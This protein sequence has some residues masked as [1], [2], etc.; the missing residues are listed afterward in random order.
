MTSVSIVVVT[1][2]GLQVLRDCVTALAEQ[3]IPH[4]LIVVDNG[5]RDGTVKWLR[6]N[7]PRARVVSLQHNLGFAA[8]NNAGLRAATGELLVL[9]NNDTIAAPDFVEQLVSP[10]EHDRQLAAAAG[11]L[12]FAH[13]PDLVA[14][15]GIAVGRDGLHRDLWMLRPVAQLPDTTTPVFGA[16]GGAACYR[17]T[18]LED[19]GLLDE[20]YGSYLE[21]ADLAWRLRLGGWDCVSVPRARVRHVYSAT[22]SHG[23][24]FKQ[25]LQARNRVRVLVRCLPAWL[26]EKHW[27]AIMRYDLLAIAYGVLRRQ[28][29][30]IA[31]RLDAIRDMPALLGQRRRLA[32]RKRVPGA[33][34]ERWLEPSATVREILR[35]QRDLD[36]VLRSRKI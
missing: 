23:S 2:D 17:R 36:A 6:Q 10:F 12:L 13:Q 16:S 28:P 34:L 32:Q 30:L 21:D 11:V 4:E 33:T 9:L 22:A 27:P 24:P 26:W 31:G 15:A 20:R 25:R 29:A 5:S 19:V 18:A 3:S 14:S 7:A 35:Q 8:G 1:W